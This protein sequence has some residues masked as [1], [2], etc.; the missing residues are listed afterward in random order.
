MREIPKGYLEKAGTQ[1]T[2][3]KIPYGEKYVLLYCPKGEAKSIFYLIHG[4]G[5]NQERFFCPEFLNMVDHMIETGELEPMYI[6]SPTY[7][8]PGETDKSPGHSGTAVAKFSAELRNAIIPAVSQY[9]G[10]TF[11]RTHRAIGGFSM[12]GVTTWYAF[13]EA[14]DLFYWFMPMSGDCWA[15]GEKGGGDHPDETAKAL[16]DAA[17]R[18]PE[19]DFRIHAMTGTKDIAFP[20][21]DPQ[22]KAMEKYPDVFGK[23][24]RYETLEGGV[25]D[26]DTI[27]RYLYHGM[28]GLFQAP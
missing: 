27:F 4:G 7:Y 23:R 5:G 24:V 9:L 26:Y 22:M 17:S 6:V 15:M 12:G 14:L 28:P 11:D 19:C 20:N 18:Q 2:I 25:H 21:L 8:D 16:Y 1:G 3:Q 10:Q 13:L